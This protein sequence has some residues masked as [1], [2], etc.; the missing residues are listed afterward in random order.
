MSIFFGYKQV[1]VGGRVGSK[2]VMVTTAITT[3]SWVSTLLTETSQRQRLIKGRWMGR[4]T[5][6]DSECCVPRRGHETETQ[7][8]HIEY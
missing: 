4:S 6:G 8:I 2:D 3:K 7:V 1:G 5:M